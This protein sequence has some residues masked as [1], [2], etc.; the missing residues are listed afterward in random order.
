MGI[1]IVDGQQIEISDRDRLNGIEVARRI[2]VEIPHYCWHPGLSDRFESFAALVDDER[3]S[4]KDLE[5][6]D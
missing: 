1:V 4:A 6:D 5:E 3:A 2:G